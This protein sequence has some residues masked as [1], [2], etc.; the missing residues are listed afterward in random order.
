MEIVQLNGHTSMLPFDLIHFKLEAQNVAVCVWLTV[1]LAIYSYN[2][3]TRCAALYF[4]SLPLLYMFRSISVHHQEAK[5]GN[6]TCFT[7]KATV[8]RPDWPADSHFNS[9]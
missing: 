2:E 6:G 3:P 5:C 4:M 9:K 7:V 8:G 1:Q